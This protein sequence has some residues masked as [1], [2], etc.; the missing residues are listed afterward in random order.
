VDVDEV[1]LVVSA[2][3]MGHALFSR[4]GFEEW[5]LVVVPGYEKGPKPIGIWFAQRPVP[6]RASSEL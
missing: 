5:E 1:P 2:S 3:P 4:V 6:K